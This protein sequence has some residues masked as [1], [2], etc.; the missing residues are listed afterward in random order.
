MTPDESQYPPRPPRH[1]V[2]KGAKIVSLNNW[3]VTDCTLRNLSDRG[4][5]IICENQATVPNEFRLMIPTDNTI[6]NAHVIWRKDDMVGIEFTSPPTR[7]PARK[8]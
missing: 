6:R 8:V 4:A 3:S 7:A 2:L 1:R 5:R